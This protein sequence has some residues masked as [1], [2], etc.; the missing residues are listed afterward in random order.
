MS[1]G[2]RVHLKLRR[3]EKGW[4]CRMSGE[5]KRGI[6]NSLC[7]RGMDLFYTD[8]LVNNQ[9]QGTSL[10]MLFQLGS[11]NLFGI[12]NMVHCDLASVQNI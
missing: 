3:P 2:E 6:F 12:A 7:A 4:L 10:S 8:I 5:G 1:K 11:S 9:L